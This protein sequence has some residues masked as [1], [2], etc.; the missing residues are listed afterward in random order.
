[1]LTHLTRI[2]QKSRRAACNARCMSTSVAAGAGAGQEQWQGW[3]AAALGAGVVSVLG[4]SAL[5]PVAD[6]NSPQAHARAKAAKAKGCP[7]PLDPS[8]IPAASQPGVKPLNPKFGRVVQGVMMYTHDELKQM[9]QDGRI[10]VAYRY[11]LPPSSHPA[12]P[13][14]HPYMTCTLTLA[15]TSP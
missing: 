4:A 10:V 2:A 12:L 13:L 8:A 14:S 6:C 7:M 3:G 15:L 9:C 5:L 1:M 11:P